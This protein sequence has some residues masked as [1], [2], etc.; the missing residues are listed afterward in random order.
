MWI[1]VNMLFYLKCSAGLLHLHAKHYIEVFGFRSCLFVVF[2]AFVILRVI[3]ILNICS[4]IFVINGAVDAV[5][6]K[7]L[8]KFGFFVILTREIYHRSGFTLLVNHKQRRNACSL[9]HSGVVGTK[10]RCNVHNTRTIFGGHIV[11][12]DNT[13]CLAILYHYIVAFFCHWLHPWE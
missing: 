4:G 1:V 12:G 8:V 5:C 9:C 3:S 13:E 2:S 10:G 6:S 7:P 11:A